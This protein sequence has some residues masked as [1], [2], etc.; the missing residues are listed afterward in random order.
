MTLTTSGRRKRVEFDVKYTG[1]SSLRDTPAQIIVRQGLNRHDVVEVIYQQTQPWMSTLTTG[2]PVSIGWGNQ[3][4]LHNIAG[5]VTHTSPITSV[6]INQPAKVF[7]VG[8]TFPLKER[9]TDLWLDYTAPQIAR[10]IARKF[11]LGIHVDDDTTY[12]LPQVAQAGRTYWEVLL[13]I[14][15][16]AGYVVRCEGVTIIFRRRDAMIDSGMASA[17]VLSMGGELKNAGN[18]SPERSLWHFR[19]KI[20]G[21]LE[22]GPS[23]AAQSV[24]GVDPVTAE[25]VSTTSTPG[26]NS[27]RKVSYDPYFTDF[28]SDRVVTSHYMAQKT[29]EA[30]SERVRMSVQADATAAGDARTRPGMPV[31]VRGTGST[32]DGYWLVDSVNHTLFASGEYEMELKLVTDSIGESAGG[33]FR[34]SSPPSRPLRD[35]GPTAMVAERPYLTPNLLPAR[36]GTTGQYWAAGGSK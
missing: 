33:S 6:T 28:P 1:Q 2:V 34:P 21:Y 36:S 5:Y 9:G 10:L 14:A 25:Y 35:L 32:T 13:D 24:A 16:R 26:G 7:C 4:G 18:L 15:D 8:A 27:L 29:S 22:S 19:P 12:R 20:G 23:L 3:S 31:Y 30:K 17:P 11:R